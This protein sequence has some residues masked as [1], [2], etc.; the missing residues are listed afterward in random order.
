[1]LERLGGHS[2]TSSH[3]ALRY[4]HW[5]DVVVR[6]DLDFG[7]QLAVDSEIAFGATVLDILDSYLS[8]VSTYR[9]R[10]YTVSPNLYLGSCIAFSYRS[11]SPVNKAVRIMTV[12]RSIFQ[13]MSVLRR[14]KDCLLTVLAD[15]ADQDF[16]IFPRHFW[17]DILRHF[18]R[19]PAG[20]C[21]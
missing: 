14:C 3:S 6:R 10:K 20:V 21:R 18:A 1:M 5:P 11:H 15:S 13:S 7:S 8:C 12:M 17:P 4:L 2:G 9:A 19:L 16:T